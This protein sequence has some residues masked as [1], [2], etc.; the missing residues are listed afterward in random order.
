MQTHS[1]LTA[2]CAVG[3]SALGG[4]GVFAREPIAAGE[5]A[6]VFGGV[7][8]T[9]AELS[10]RRRSEPGIDNRCVMVADGFLITPECHTHIDDAERLNHSCD[11]N[12]GVVGQVVLVAR[13]PI[14]AGEEVTFDYDT[15]ELDMPPFA[16]RCGSPH[17]RGL[18]DG[19]GWRRPEFRTRYAG[20]LAPHVEAAARREFCTHDETR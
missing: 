3:P 14:A 20:F 10:D 9:T 2:K 17:C 13:R 4:L 7:V 11:A 12:L 8:I 5:T 15:T 19:T 1:W 16:C 18:I 6:C